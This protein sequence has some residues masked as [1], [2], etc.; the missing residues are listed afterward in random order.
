[1]GAAH[2]RH[3]GKLLAMKGVFP[4]EELAVAKLRS[5]QVQV[6]PLA[7]PGL[8]AQRHLIIIGMV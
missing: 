3:G 5:E 1:M 4:S 2:C 7:V 8:D 6:I